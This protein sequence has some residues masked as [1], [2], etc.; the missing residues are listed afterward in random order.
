L[1]GAAVVAELISAGHAVTG[2]ARSDKSAAR[3]RELGA[4]VL[5]GSLDELEA[6]ADGA[7]A[8]EGVIH[9][10]FGE[11]FSDPQGMAR[12]D[13]AAISALGQALAGS[14]KPLVSTSGTLAM[15]H[16]KV[17]TEHDAPDP[18]S[19]GSLRIPGE[20]TRMSGLQ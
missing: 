3:L 7:R 8:A 1:T 10:A 16:G 20:Q 17:T 12:R 11:D 14:G 15:E 13:C 6:L 2:L 18:R 19:L 4:D 9:M 5:N